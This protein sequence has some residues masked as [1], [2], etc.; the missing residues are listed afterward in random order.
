[1]R[2]AAA[3]LVLALIAACAREPAQDG[4]TGPKYVAMGSSFA[5]GPGIAQPVEAAPARCGRSED[6][7]AHQLARL[8][9]LHLVDVSC[10]GATT[11]HVIGRWNELPAQ[12]DAVDAATQLVTV[13]IGGNDLGYVDGLFKGAECM[14]ARGAGCPAEPAP[15][16]AAYAELE[17]RMSRIASEV[18]R[19]A[20]SARLIFVDYVTVL[21][22]HELC[23]A[24]P[25]SAAQ[26]EAS[27]TI[28]R[29]LAEITARTAEQNG[30]EVLRLSELSREHHA[31]AAEP[32]L[33]GYLP[34]GASGA[35]YH[36]NLAGMTAAAAALDEMLSH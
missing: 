11:R 5:A 31:C 7:Y 22:E 13:T 2:L 28:A 4:A 9:G 3:Y 10:A 17:Q 21:P 12:I 33:N 19:R 1:M 15:S 25:L 14:G 27:R 29:R 35:S 30:A 20:P 36:L 24:T 6:N 32:W 23:A 18:R 26:A 8:R 16:E 34:R